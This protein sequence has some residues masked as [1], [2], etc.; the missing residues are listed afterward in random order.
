MYHLYPRMLAVH[1]LSDSIAL[2]HPE[3]GLIK[4]PSLMR[5]SHVFMKANGIYLVGEDAVP[6]L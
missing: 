4:M 1:D 5:G 2:P 3:T 6:L